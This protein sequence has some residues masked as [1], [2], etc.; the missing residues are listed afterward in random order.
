M[1]LSN[2]F[3]K[4]RFE[5]VASAIGHTP[6]VRLNRVTGD[7]QPAVYAKLE[8][9]NPGGSVKDRIGI[10]IID[11]FEHS[12]ELKPGGTV[13]EATSGNTGVG[14]A[15]ICAMRGYQSVFVMPDKMSQE[16]IDTL[17]AYGAR[18]VVTP[19]AVEPDDPR[20]YYSV[21]RRIVDETPNAILA[22][23]YHNPANP[24]SHYETTAPEI[25]DQTDGKVTDIVLGMGTGGTIT[26]LARYF[27]DE[28]HDVKIVGVDPE[29][30]ILYD[31]WKQGGDPSGLQA[32]TYLVEGIGEDFIPGTLD[33]SLVDAVVRVSD[34][35]SF[36]WTRRVVREEGIFCG[37]SCGSALAGAMKYAQDLGPERIVVVIFP[38]SGSRYLSKVFDDDWMREHGML[39]AEREPVSVRQVAG[40]VGRSEL[41]MATPDDQ[42]VEVMRRMRADAIS[43]LPVID[44]EGLLLGVVSEV[45]LLN[46]LLNADH[47]HAPDETIET[48]VNRDVPR[49]VSSMLFDQV[50][51]ELMDAKMVILTD[52]EGHP[53]G[54]LTMIDAL[55]YVTG[56]ELC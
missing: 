15:M 1:S 44:R 31:A 9:M 34:A 10:S 25:W 51:P 22:N 18:V 37:G 32:E 24:Q 42:V 54:I 7:V 39:P 8:M 35:E 29:G 5:S 41:I 46:H 53:E 33:L 6:L 27:R 28:G 56:R 47:E 16:K 12:G 20:S 3:S 48:M 52:D 45:D 49:A 40:S 23:Q 14:L 13:V 38:D 4:R 30:S 2:D 55:E 17:R 50:L 11:A 26:G 19:T 21:A 43:Q 36:S